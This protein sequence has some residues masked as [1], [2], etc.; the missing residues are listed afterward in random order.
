MEFVASVLGTYGIAYIVSNL[1]GPWGFFYRLRYT[2]AEPFSCF[3][4]ITP[5]LAAAIS[6]LATSSLAGWAINTA[7][8]IGGAYLIQK[9]IE[10][11]LV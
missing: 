10:S 2:F 5:Y 6:I 3:Y 9:I 8:C 7:G 4:C 11:R 1:D